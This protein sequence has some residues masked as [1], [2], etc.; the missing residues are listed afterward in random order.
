MKAKTVIKDMVRDVNSR[1][2][3]NKITIE[4]KNTIVSYLES[5]CKLREFALTFT[6]TK[7]NKSLVARRK[8]P[9][10]KQSNKKFAT[11]SDEYRNVYLRGS[12]WKQQRKLV[13][14]N[15][16]EKNGGVSKCD[17]CGVNSVIRPLDV[18]H[19]VYRKTDMDDPECIKDKF[20]L[21][22]PCHDLI[23]NMACKEISLRKATDIVL[24]TKGVGL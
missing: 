3:S 13:L 21:C 24:E 1:Y 12:I 8:K 11:K 18:H 22:R 7:K 17:A 9:K 16:K 6:T 2:A 20:V 14:D 10:D 15:N 5:Y 4:Q 19:R 23:H